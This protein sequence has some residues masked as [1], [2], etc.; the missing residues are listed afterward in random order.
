MLYSCLML[1]R[2]CGWDGLVETCCDSVVDVVECC[3]V[4]YVMCY[5]RKNHLLECVITDR[6]DIGLYDVLMLMSLFGLG[7]GMMFGS[8]QT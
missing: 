4:W 1:L 5:V 2:W 3:D 7:I 6:R 8:F